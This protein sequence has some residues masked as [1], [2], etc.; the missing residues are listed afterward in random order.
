M[1]CTSTDFSKTLVT[2]VADTMDA[3]GLSALPRPSAFALMDAADEHRCSRRCR[4]DADNMDM[5][6]G[7]ALIPFAF[8]R[9]R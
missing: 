4:G 1:G 5:M 7:K 2:A 9:M 6:I 3:V 8:L